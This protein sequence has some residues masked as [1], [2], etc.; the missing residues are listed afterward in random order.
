[1]PQQVNLFHPVLLAPRRH[2]P[3]LAVVRA[4]GLWALALAALSGWVIWR[5]QVL[6]TELAQAQTGHAA[7]QQQL[8]LAL[9]QRS[10]ASSD[11]A[12]L[13]QELA[14]LQARRAGRQRLLDDLGGADATSPTA[15]LLHLAQTLPPAV[16]L[17]QIRWSPA[18]WSL[19]GQTL[20]PEALRHWLA[21]QGPTHALRVARQTDGATGWSFRAAQGSDTP[22]APTP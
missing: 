15:L 21:S 14:A 11:P 22:E 12:V 16:W 19:Q 6:H 8:Q 3:A 17:D 20:E 5:T 4:L 18:G 13:Q 2:F 10:A 1:M 7:E 9:A